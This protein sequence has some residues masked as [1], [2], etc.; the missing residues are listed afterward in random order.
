MRKYKDLYDKIKVLLSQDNT[1]QV[2]NDTDE[3]VKKVQG[4]LTDING[5]IIYF[6]NEEGILAVGDNVFSDKEMTTPLADGE[7]ETSDGYLLKVEGGVLVEIVD[8]LGEQFS[9]LESRNNEMSD[10]IKEYED[11]IK[12]YEEKIEN[13]ESNLST[14]SKKSDEYE[15]TIHKLQSKIDIISTEPSIDSI[16]NTPV[17]LKVSIDDRR[18][19]LMNQYKEY[20]KNN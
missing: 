15:K 20:L 9:K 7:Y 5:V 14:F 8:L 4:E 10:K 6:E 17:D 13:L 2:D 1:E 16:S 11:K 12:E 18:M 3:S 19:E